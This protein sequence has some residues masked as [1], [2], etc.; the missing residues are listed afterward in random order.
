MQTNTFSFVQNFGTVFGIIFKHEK[1]R[2]STIATEVSRK[3]KDFTKLIKFT[4]KF[5]FLSH[6]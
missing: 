5:H 3:K 6:A 1:Q 2:S 4:L